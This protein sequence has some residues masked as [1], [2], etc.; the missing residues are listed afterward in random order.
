MPHRKPNNHANQHL[1]QYA[2]QNE[3][4]QINEGSGNLM[5]GDGL[6]SKIVI[7]GIRVKVFGGEPVV[8]GS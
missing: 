1:S 4:V 8:I 3:N 7:K 2:D 5:D 6:V